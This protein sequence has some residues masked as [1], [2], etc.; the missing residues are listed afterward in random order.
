[1]DAE[2]SSAPNAPLPADRHVRLAQDVTVAA[3]EASSIE[4][5]M[6]RAVEAVCTHCGFA[7]GHF[8][9]RPGE[10]T[11]HLLPMPV[12]YVDDADRYESFRRVTDALRLPVG[13]GLPG[14]AAVTGRPAWSSDLAADENL[15]RARWATEAG[16]VAGLAVPVLVGQEVVGVLEFFSRRSM[17]A[18]QELV[19]TLSQVGNQLG[20]VVE[21]SRT[22]QA[23]ADSEE[24]M[25]LVVE[26]SGDAFVGMDAAGLISDWNRAAESLFG[27]TRAEAIGRRL[28]DTIIPLR[29][30]A[31]HDQGV[32][33]YFDTGEAVVFGQRIELHSLHRD[34]HETPVELSIW[35]VRAGGTVEFNAFVHDISERRQAQA[36]TERF[37][38]AFDDAPIGMVL[39]DAGGRFVQANR[40]YRDMLGYAEDELV[41]MTFA[42]ITPDEEHAA[43]TELFERLLA[44]ELR[45]HRFETRCIHADGHLVWVLLSASAVPSAEGTVGYLIVQL[46]DISD[47][48]AA[49]TELARR[50]LHD[51]LTGLANRSLLMDRLRQAIARAQRD[52][53]CFALMFLDLDHFKRVNDTLGHGAGDQLLCTIADRLVASL[54]PFDTS[55]R[56]GGDEFVVL[57]ERGGEDEARALAGRVVA[58][59]H[60]PCTLGA[61]EVRVTASVGVVMAG[62]ALVDAP[63]LLREADSAMYRAKRGGRARSEVVDRR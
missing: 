9:D 49:E 33:R 52:D 61:E 12:W 19:E 18:D 46:E 53:T 50:A 11:G 30:R 5:A 23:L 44:G 62:P 1:M 35:P 55:V 3:N 17:G 43:T 14:R 16:L 34:G 41:E 24:R 48:K 32:A 13:Q 29:Y 22:A 63:G 10:G 21:R 6:G 15:P 7:V 37:E 56:L 47:R 25:R 40:A 39:S 38:I 42:D 59:V 8:Y 2:R 58:A 60:A 57:C 45:S 51:P 4:D 26:T 27:W 20:R 54:R 36:A 28:S 31:A